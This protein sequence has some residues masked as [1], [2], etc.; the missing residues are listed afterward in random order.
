M[1]LTVNVFGSPICILAFTTIQ[2][3]IDRSRKMQPDISENGR[4][5]GVDGGKRYAGDFH[6]CLHCNFPGCLMWIILS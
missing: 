2:E 4:I 1:Y 5:L 6:Q 3:I